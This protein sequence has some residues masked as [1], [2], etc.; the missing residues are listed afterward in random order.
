MERIFFLKRTWTYCKEDRQKV[1]HNDLETTT[2]PGEILPSSVLKDEIYV[3][4]LI[5][6]IHFVCSSHNWARNLIKNNQKMGLPSYL[7]RGTF[8][9]STRIDFEK[10]DPSLIGIWSIMYNPFRP[11]LQNCSQFSLCVLFVVNG[12]PLKV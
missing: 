10:L 2:R 8:W 6:V 11:K 12:L 4:K 7:F 1:N 9:K 3:F 5:G